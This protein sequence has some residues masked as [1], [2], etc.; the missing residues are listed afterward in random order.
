MKN[1]EI[2]FILKPDLDEDGLRAEMDAIK[3]S[4][5]KKRGKTEEL[6]IWQKRQLAYKIKKFK[7]GIYILGLFKLSSDSPRLLSKDW[8]LNS[9]ILRF[10]IL[11]KEN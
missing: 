9:N 8:R 2:M 3:E 4:V 6:N 10:L 1:Y 7:E 11:K 5:S